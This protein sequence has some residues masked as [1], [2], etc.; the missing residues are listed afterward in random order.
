MERI[1]IAAVIVAVVAG[2]A[3]VARAR[4]TTDAPTQSRVAFPQ[5][6]D[7]RDF[8]DPDVPWLVV[9]FTS[10]TCNACSLVVDKAKVLATSEVAV[11]VAEFPTERE[12]HERYSIDA[13]PTLIVVDS[14]GVAR[15]AFRGPMT[16]TDLW[17]AVAEVREPGSTPGSD[18]GC[19]KNAG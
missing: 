14:A 19:A 12:L 4:R 11:A 9:V 15:A 3:L 18:L 2:V 16:A 17:A 1:V 6:V 13:V 8:A 5:Q 7:R 10:S